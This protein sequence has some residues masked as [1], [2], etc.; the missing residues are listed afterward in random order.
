MQDITET[1]AKLK[2][3]RRTSGTNIKGI[4]EGAKILNR[5]FGYD[6]TKVEIKES[7]STRDEAKQ[8]SVEELKALA[9]ANKDTGESTESD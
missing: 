3:Q 6:I 2:K 9:Y 4:Y 7:D 1:I 5:M 8:L